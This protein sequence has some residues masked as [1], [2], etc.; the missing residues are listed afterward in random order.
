MFNELK[1][2]IILEWRDSDKWTIKINHILFDL[3]GGIRYILFWMNEDYLSLSGTS[4]LISLLVSQHED[5]V[6]YSDYSC[7]IN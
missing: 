6:G 7:L 1:G 5:I 3:T 2:Q 4:S